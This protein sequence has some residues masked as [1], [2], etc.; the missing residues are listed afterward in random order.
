MVGQLVEGHADEVREVH[1]RHGAG[2]REGGSQGRAHD[3]RLAD[4]DV[5]DPAAEL[6]GQTLELP[7]DA[8]LPHDILAVD[9]DGGIA[10]HLFL[11]G[12]QGSF[13]E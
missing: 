7:E 6:L 5:P 11:H 10:P 9:E 1:I 13:A 8:A 2:A 3:S 4:G 12:L